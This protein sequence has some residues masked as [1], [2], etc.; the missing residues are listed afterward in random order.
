MTTPDEFA[1]NLRSL[2]TFDNLV[3]DMKTTIFTKP[4]GFTITTL[5]ANG[6]M[7]VVIDKFCA[8]LEEQDDGKV[9]Y[10][11]FGRNHSETLVNGEMELVDCRFLEDDDR[12]RDG[13]K[14]FKRLCDVHPPDFER[15]IEEDLEKH[16]IIETIIDSWMLAG[17]KMMYGVH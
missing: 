7:V 5:T 9:A 13:V 17:E 16:E 4:R 12:F 2:E 14:Y 8:I 11:A 6:T 1:A 10:V 3:E 15:T